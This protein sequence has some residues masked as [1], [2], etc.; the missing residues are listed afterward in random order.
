[1]VIVIGAVFGIVSVFANKQYT[2]D[3]ISKALGAFQGALI[4]LLGFYVYIPAATVTRIGAAVAAGI[5]VYGVWR[6]GNGP[7]RKRINSGQGSLL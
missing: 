2:T 4:Q 5:V 6:K 7:V 1:V 3:D